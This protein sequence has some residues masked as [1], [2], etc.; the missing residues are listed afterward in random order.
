[1]LPIRRAT[2]CDPLATESRARDGYAN[3]RPT[4]YVPRAPEWRAFVGGRGHGMWSFPKRVTIILLVTG[5]AVVGTVLAPGVGSSAEPVASSDRPVPGKTRQGVEPLRSM[6]HGNLGQI[7]ARAAARRAAVAPATANPD[8][9]IPPVKRPNAAP[10]TRTAPDRAPDPTLTPVSDRFPGALP[11]ESLS[12]GD[13]RYADGGN[14][15][16]GEPPDQALCVG[17]G[18][19][20]AGVNQAIAVY[21]RQGAQLAPT[22]SINEFFRLA[23]PIDR[24]DPNRPT[25]G[26]F[27]F[28]PVCLYEPEIKRWIF[29]VTELDQAPFTGDFTGGS[30]IFFAVSAT[31]DPLGDYAFYAIN[32]TGGDSTDRACPCLDD[33]PHI[34]SDQN[35]FYISVNR[36]S[37]FNAPFNGAQIYALSKHRLAANAADPSRRAPTLVSINAGP[38]DGDPSFTV[39]PMTVPP[40]GAYPGDREYFLS[41]TDFDTVREDK[42]GVW[43]LANTDSLTQVEPQV[44]LSRDTTPSLPYV[45]EPRVEQRPGRAPLAA[46][47]G[48]RLNRLDSGSDMSEVKF[49]R[50]RLWGAIGTAV[51]RGADQRDGVLWVQVQPTF[52]GGGV[53]GQV[54]EQGYLATRTNSLIYPAVGVNSAGEGGMVMT[55]AGP[56]VYPSP[57]YV[58]IGLGGVTGPVRVPEFGQR[59]DDGF[60]CYAALVGSRARGC[61][62]GDYSSAVADERGRIWMATEWIPNGSRIPLAN[63]STFAIRLNLDNAPG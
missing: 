24:T 51:G 36:F 21:D 3:T 49:A 43:A 56:T 6:G 25:F 38:I 47:V 42:V 46:S 31:A 18:F 50:G 53:S 59:P 28:D 57:A 7:A 35:G 4:C 11:F 37:I 19:T 32:T 48:E 12:A 44:R 1:V 23:P 2:V 16:S 45:F 13:S 60:T 26:P 63:W 27:A 41:S 54:V 14:Q 10:D 15:F 22:V 17:S 61:R 40:G 5:L 30:N 39:Q 52:V 62:W 29:L 58:Q 33:F 9:E 55:L 34:G 20:M 8:T